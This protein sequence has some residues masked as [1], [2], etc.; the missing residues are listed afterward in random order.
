MYACH[1]AMTNAFETNPID[2]SRAERL[3][4]TFWLACFGDPILE[5][6]IGCLKEQALSIALKAPISE[7]QGLKMSFRQLQDVHGLET[8]GSIP[9]ADA[10][11]RPIERYEG[12]RLALI[13]AIK[14]R[15]TAHSSRT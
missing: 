1:E 7:L 8:V 12:L 11:G 15:E 6:L 2:Q 9:T 4:D 14:A 10:H 5:A 3:F 13:A